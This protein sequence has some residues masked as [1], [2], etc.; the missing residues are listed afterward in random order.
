MSV[1]P[2]IKALEGAVF[3]SLDERIS[4]LLERG[5]GL[6]PTASNLSAFIEQCRHRASV[7]GISDSA[8]L[9]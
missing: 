8:Y 5:L 2:D 9:D 3:S 7:L 6:A 4:A 1:I